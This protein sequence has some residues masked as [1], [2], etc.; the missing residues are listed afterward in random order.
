MAAGALYAGGL[1]S[2]WGWY[3]GRGTQAKSILSVAKMIWTSCATSPYCSHHEAAMFS[4]PAWVNVVTRETVPPR[5][6][7]ATTDEPAMPLTNVQPAQ[8]DATI[9][10]SANQRDGRTGFP[11]LSLL[12]PAS[13]KKLNLPTPR[14]GRATGRRVGR[15]HRVRGAR[16][17]GGT[18]RETAPTMRHRVPSRPLGCRRPAL[19]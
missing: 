13:L 10:Q 17:S 6:S 8:T 15:F 14:L 11:Y 1:N 5:W 18:E 3:A 9:P 4:A 12:A 19:P 16:R 7:P 2:G